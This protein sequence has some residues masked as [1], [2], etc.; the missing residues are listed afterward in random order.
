MK[1]KIILIV[2]LLGLA[3]LL[4]FYFYI[5]QSE[6]SKNLNTTN[7]STLDSYLYTNFGFTLNLD[8][9]TEKSIGIYCDPAIPTTATEELQISYPC[10]NQNPKH[11]ILIGWA[12]ASMKYLTVQKNIGD[13]QLLLK[14]GNKIETGSQT[15]IANE[16][17][18]KFS[19]VQIGTD[20]VMSLPGQ[21]G[22]SSIVFLN[23]NKSRK[24]FLIVMNTK[25]STS[26]KEVE[27]E[28][29][30]LLEKVGTKNNGSEKVL[31][32]PLVE[33]TYAFEGD[34]ASGSQSC[35]NSNI[36]G[37]SAATGCG[38]DPNG[39]N[40]G[41]GDAVVCDINNV[42]IC[43][44]VY[45]DS[46]TA[47][48]DYA[49]AKCAEKSIP[50]EIDGDV[51]LR[52]GSQPDPVAINITSSKAGIPQGETAVISWSAPGATS[53]TALGGWTGSKS[54]TGSTFNVSNINTTSAVMPV[55]YYLRCTD[56]KRTQTKGIR[57]Y[58]FQVVPVGPF[59]GNW[60]GN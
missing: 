11:T 41:T 53:C 46:A 22:Y 27:S 44:L 3:F 8:S 51:G 18:A 1:N 37:Q 43:Y 10:V 49:T 26:A 48:W 29:I 47:I 34:G 55:V 4:G 35:V 16:N 42:T 58:H 45:C 24:I 15:C 54:T 28:M 7:L 13:Q 30:K 14:S 2:G 33:K 38:T 19:G 9:Q 57:L 12:D 39:T 23:E 21:K 50:V 31:M 36:A 56:G 32:T 60:G 40:G 5:K 52:F 20:C 6:N 59:D 17:Y 25:K